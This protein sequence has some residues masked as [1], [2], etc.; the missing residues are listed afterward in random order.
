MFFKKKKPLLTADTCSQE[1]I[2][3]FAVT[4][5]KTFEGEGTFDFTVKSLKDVDSC[6]ETMSAFAKINRKAKERTR[7]MAGCYILEVAR[8]NYGGTYQ[9]WDAHEIPVLMYGMPEN[10]IGIATFNK[11]VN[12]IN[13]GD[14][15]NIPFFFQGFI[16]LVNRSKSENRVDAILV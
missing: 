11:V 5:A 9:W 10:A 12:R 14:A 1:K 8:R 2:E 13:N 16:E 6:I 4:F 7:C 3:F 15:D